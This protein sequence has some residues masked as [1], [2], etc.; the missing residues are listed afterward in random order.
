MNRDHLSDQELERWRA[1]GDPADRER[2][3]GHLVVCEACRQ[4]LIEKVGAGDAVAF[5]IA[6]FA[7]RG[8][9]VYAQPRRRFALWIGAG[10]VVAAAALLMLSLRPP[11]D[12]PS[13]VRG[14]DIRARVP[15][16][17]VASVTEFRWTSPVNAAK[18]HIRV[19][20]AAGSVIEGES[21]TET[22]TPPA[23]LQLPAGSYTWTIDALDAAGN[24]IISSRPQAFEVRVR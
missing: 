9:E 13:S 7:A 12:G 19:T 24:V 15:V 21:T 22:W 1:Q 4:R 23:G 3:L 11:S 6:R 5:D 20:S 10:G 2:V 14:S 17:E 8:V 18:Y 16:D